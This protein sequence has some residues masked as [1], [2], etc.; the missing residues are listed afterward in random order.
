MPADDDVGGQA[1]RA[2]EE[3]SLE[4]QP[5]VEV[6]EWPLVT[7]VEPNADV[8]SAGVGNQLPQESAL[9]ATHFHDA[10]AAHPLNLDQFAHQ[11][12]DMPLEC[13]GQ[14]LGVVVIGAV[15]QEAGVEGGVE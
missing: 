12:G 3:T 14:G 15:A 13:C 10:A 8:G 5:P 7:G 1:S 6:G 2:V 4:P 11:P 9:A